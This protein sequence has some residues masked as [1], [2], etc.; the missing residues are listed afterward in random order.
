[1]IKRKTDFSRAKFNA[2]QGVIIHHMPSG[3]IHEQMM[4][5]FLEWCSGRANQHPSLSVLDR[6]PPH[7][8]SSLQEHARELWIEL[9]FISAGGTSKF[10]PLDHR[11]FGE[12]KSRARRAFERL[13]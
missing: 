5:Q 11:A 7:R 6:D 9:L 4:V 2:R 8:T 1:L 10:E 13:A 3:W 12:L